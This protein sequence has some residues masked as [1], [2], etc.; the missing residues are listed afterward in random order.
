MQK[1]ST[2]LIQILKLGNQIEVISMLKS[3]KTKTKPGTV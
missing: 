3:K 2:S 1:I